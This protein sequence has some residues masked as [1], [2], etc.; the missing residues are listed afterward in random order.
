VIDAADVG[1]TEAEDTVD[2]TEGFELA[3]YA[4]QELGPLVELLG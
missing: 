1:D 4:T 2:D 3:W